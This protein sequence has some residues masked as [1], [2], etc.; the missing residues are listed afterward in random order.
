[1]HFT[2]D[3][4]DD[5][6]TLD[7]IAHTFIGIFGLHGLAI[8]ILLASCRGYESMMLRDFTRW[9]SFTFA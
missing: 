7:V 8:A 9:Y 3:R 6:S 5:E 4:F 2:S 1:M